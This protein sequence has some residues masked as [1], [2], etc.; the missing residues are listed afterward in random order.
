MEHTPKQILEANSARQ[1]LRHLLKG[2]GPRSRLGPIRD[3]RHVKGPVRAW[4]FFIINRQGSGDF[5][6]IPNLKKFGLMR[7]EWKALSDGEREVRG[8]LPALRRDTFVDPTVQKYKDLERS[9]ISR[10]LEECQ[11]VYG[12]PGKTPIKVTK[13]TS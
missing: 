5:K 11:S 6:G 4:S 2:Y 7:Q 13:T 9:D 3:E 10:Y 12:M 8:A 1:Q